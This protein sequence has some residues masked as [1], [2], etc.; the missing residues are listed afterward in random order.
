MPEPILEFIGDAPFWV[1]PLLLILYFWAKSNYDA[2]AN[3]DKHPASFNRLVGWLKENN[4]G[5]L[6]LNALG[7]LIDKVSGWIGDQAKM[8]CIYDPASQHQS[9][10]CKSFGFNPFTAESYEKSLRLAFLYPLL[11]FLLAWALGSLGQVGGVDWMGKDAVSL[12]ST[13]RWLFLVGLFAVLLGSIWLLRHWQGWRQWLVLALLFLALSVLA[14]SLGSTENIAITYL[15]FWLAFLLIFLPF[16]SGAWLIAYAYY[17]SAKQAH[18]F[19]YFTAVAVAVAVA[20]VGAVAG[21]LFTI[22]QIS[23]QQAASSWILA[24]LHIAIFSGR[25]CQPEII[26]QS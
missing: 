15:L 11:S 4:F 22:L 24:S 14:K 20:F 7:W 10:I 21:A 3:H 26:T 17:R 12:T 25:R 16:Y 5:L 2:L 1:L 23:L 13:Q 8:D 19:V 18:Q 9:F 6:Y